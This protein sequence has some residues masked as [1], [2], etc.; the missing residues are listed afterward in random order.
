MESRQSGYRISNTATSSPFSVSVV[1]PSCHASE[2]PRANSRQNIGSRPSSVIVAVRRSGLSPQERFKGYIR[3]I[4]G[5][6]AFV[7]FTAKRFVY[8]SAAALGTPLFPL[9]FVRTLNASDAW[10]GAINTAQTAIVLIGYPFW[11][12]QWRRRGAWR[13]PRSAPGTCSGLLFRTSG[14]HSGSRRT[15]RTYDYK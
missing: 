10:I 9:Y 12:Q 1:F 4:W 6:K 8:L 7:S 3:L 11:S 13:W 15:W 14:R 5:E 2:L